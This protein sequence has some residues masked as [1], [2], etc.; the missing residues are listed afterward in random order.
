[1]VKVI[2]VDGLPTEW[3]EGIDPKY[4]RKYYFNRRT[5]TSTWTVPNFELDR[6]F[7]ELSTDE[8]QKD[9]STSSPSEPYS[10]NGYYQRAET[11]RSDD[12]VEKFSPDHDRSYFVNRLTKE[13]SWDDPRNGANLNTRIRNKP[14]AREPSKMR[15]I[16]ALQ[17]AWEDIEKARMQLQRER[18]ELS[19]RMRTEWKLLQA[20]LEELK[21]LKKSTSFTPES[22]PND[23][24]REANGIE[25]ESSDT[26]EP[27]DEDD[28]SESESD[29]DMNDLDK[30]LGDL[31]KRT[32]EIY[33]Q[34]DYMWSFEESEDENSDDDDDEDRV[35][36]L[37]RK[38]KRRMRRNKG[39]GAK[40]DML[41]M[42]MDT[43]EDIKSGMKAVKDEKKAKQEAAEQ[44]AGIEE[45][46]F[47]KI[48]GVEKNAT[49]GQLRKAYHKLMILWHPD[50][51]RDNIEE[52][53]RKANLVKDAYECLSNK[54]ERH[55][56]DK[57][58]LEGYLFHCKMIQTFKNYL[59]SGLKIKKHG[60]NGKRY[61]IEA[62]G[63][64]Y[65]SPKRR[66]LW[67][68]HQGTH[69]CTGP[70]RILEAV[71]EREKASIKQV[72]VQDV[73]EIKKGK[74]TE[75]FERTGVESKARR[76]FSIVT[77]DR[78]LDIEVISLEQRDFL[79]TRIALLVIDS[80][81]NEE[82]LEKHYKEHPPK[83]KKRRKIKQRKKK[84]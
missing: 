53:N 28:D 7:Q 1:M 76:Y 11:K 40:S 2:H 15:D 84:T 45:G 43:V 41:A 22:S 4:N 39:V 63:L 26:D 69:L 51:N 18:E 35:Q 3:V 16:P 64:T 55:V 82:W 25:N 27:E 34:K 38:H 61:G 67:L 75:V 73:T 5:K 30:Y 70:V 20:Q 14:F 19:S 80:Q 71:T 56:Y 9:K 31:E 44:A 68:D 36:K 72:K 10:Q 48:M 23:S 81:K 83:K 74:S 46:D 24:R 47:Y 12:W 59:R 66:M 57:I 33:K 52:A 17:N 21:A 6:S 77:P 37:K 8:D 29:T 58:G 32:S 54:W 49:N 50:K 13:T 78:T 65:Y 42:F 60:R 62:L 79:A